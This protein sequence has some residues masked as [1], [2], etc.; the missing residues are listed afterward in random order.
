MGAGSKYKWSSISCILSAMV[1]LQNSQRGCCCVT[2][3]GVLVGMSGAVTLHLPWV[4]P[5]LMC[6]DSMFLFFFC[7]ILVSV[8]IFFVCVWWWL[9]CCCCCLWQGQEKRS[10]KHS[11]IFFENR[12][13]FYHCICFLDDI[14]LSLDCFSFASV[15][16]GLSVGYFLFYCCWSLNFIFFHLSCWCL[17]CSFGIWEELT[18]ICSG[19]FQI[20]LVL[21]S[22]SRV[23]VIAV[24]VR[25]SSLAGLNFFPS[26]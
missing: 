1:W 8:L 24:Y 2:V 9:C 5:R 15:L 3:V 23:L 10:F 18:F 17:L 26:L 21:V 25:F 4:F 6:G 13:Y 14:W 7:C 19:S 16:F 22:F 11:Y 20:M 12:L